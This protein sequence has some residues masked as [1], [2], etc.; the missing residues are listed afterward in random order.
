MAMNKAT[1]WTLGFLAATALGCSA[2]VRSTDA[3]A[4]WGRPSGPTVVARAAGPG[5]VGT[6]QLG[7]TAPVDAPD[8]AGPRR[9][10]TDFD[11]LSPRV[12][13]GASVDAVMMVPVDAKVRRERDGVRVTA[14]GFDMEVRSHAPDLY[15]RRLEM[16][17]D[18]TGVRLHHDSADT[19]VYEKL[20]GPEAGS[21]HVMM[22]MET[23]G[24]V[25]RCDDARGTRFTKAQA[26]RMVR[27]CWSLTA[28]AESTDDTVR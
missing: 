17:R 28:R 23:G 13:L 25:F 26:L 24:R 16:L 27:A 11:K 1:T 14:S 9:A 15:G 12:L 3:G 8:S 7:Y 6:P 4:A 20:T 2:S 18:P 5:E 10:A 22:M 21:F 19:L